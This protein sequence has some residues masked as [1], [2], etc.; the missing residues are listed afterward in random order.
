MPAN[1]GLT[2]FTL[3][4]KGASGCVVVFHE[5]WGLVEHTKDVCKRVSKLGFA[6]AAPDLY[7]GHG[8]L[9]TPDNIQMAMEG[10]WELSLE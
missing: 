7:S 2:R 10:L 5:V 9:L 8:R 4:P 3:T 6:A 1:G